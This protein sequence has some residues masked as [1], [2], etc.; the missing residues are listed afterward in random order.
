MNTDGS[1]RQ[2]QLLTR[3]RLLEIVPVSDVA[4][5][6]WCK[7]G[8]FTSPIKV[9]RRCFWKRAEVQAWIDRQTMKAA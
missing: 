6:R 1:D 5:W 9:G 8:T 3:A 2:D 7:S 4:L